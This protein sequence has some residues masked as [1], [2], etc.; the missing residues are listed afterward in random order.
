MAEGPLICSRR[1]FLRSAL[2]A[3]AVL[4]V[5]GV[6]LGAR[7]V[8]AALP[9]ASEVPSLYALVIDT[10]KCVGCGACTQACQ[11]RNSLAEGSSYIHIVTQG[12]PAQPTFLPVQC[13]HCV[14]PPCADVC[15]TRATYRT[16]EGVVLINEK[17]CVGCKY[18]DVACP[19][20]ARVYDEERGVVDKCGLCLA[21]VQA[22]K[23]PACVQACIL[24]ARTFGRQDDPSSEVA[25]LLA[26]GQA[27]PLHPEFG[28]QPGVVYYIL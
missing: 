24:G 4:T 9:L 15:P 19:Y 7:R 8:V 12:D 2:G 23:N 27:Q 22:G 21:D 16:E 18:C 5:G 6:A 26:S 28:T 11:V 14:N 13:Q 1:A 25:Q 3:G 10:T 17:K 20:Q